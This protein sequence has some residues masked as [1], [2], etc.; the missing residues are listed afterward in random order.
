MECA[1]AMIDGLDLLLCGR[2][3]RSGQGE[4]RDGWGEK[5]RYLKKNTRGND[6][7]FSNHFLVY[8]FQGVSL[9]YTPEI[10]PNKYSTF[11]MINW[12]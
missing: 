11:M 10:H 12:A 6:F 2:S 3:G 1:A 9:K 8:F 7:D 5:I 4:K